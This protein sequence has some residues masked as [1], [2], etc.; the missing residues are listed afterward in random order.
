VNAVKRTDQEA[1][2]WKAQFLASGR[3]ADERSYQFQRAMNWRPIPESSDPREHT[4]TVWDRIIAKAKARDMLAV[5]HSAG[6]HCTMQ[7]LRSRTADVLGRLRAVAFTD[8]VHSVSDDESRPVARFIMEHA[9][10]YVTSD[11]PLDT[12]IRRDS[13]MGEK[14]GCPCVSAGHEKH[15]FT[16]GT[17][18]PSVF[19]FLQKHLNAAIASNITTPP[20]N[21]HGGL[22]LIPSLSVRPFSVVVQSAGASNGAA[23]GVL[24]Q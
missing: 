18:F 1:A 3:R 8:S 20:Q 24:R 12:P 4:L 13:L 5:A 10:N 19:P 9:Q 21:A 22:E 7:L 16:S 6:G 14:D 2:E 15:E 11:E 23:V 17:A